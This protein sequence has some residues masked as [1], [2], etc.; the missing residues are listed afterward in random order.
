MVT[1]AFCVRGYWLIGRLNSERNPSTT[2]SRL[3]TPART[4]RRMKR[5]VNFMA[6]ASMF[7]RGGIR[8]VGRRDGVVDH[9]VRAVL[10]LDLAAGDDLLAFLQALQDRDLVAARLAGG[11]E[12]LLHDQAGARRGTG[13]RGR[14]GGA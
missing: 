9:D 6:C 4:G 3:I 5:S 11:H 14:R 8:A 10:Q 1:T 13:R 2:I 12:G 7:L